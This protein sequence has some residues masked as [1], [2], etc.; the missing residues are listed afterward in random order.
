[1]SASYF[2]LVDEA[3]VKVGGET[4]MSI[5]EAARR[6][7]VSHVTL[8]LAVKRGELKTYGHAGRST[9]ISLKEAREWKKRYYNADQANRV[10]KRWNKLVSVSEAARRLGISV[11]PLFRAIQRG[12]LKVYGTNKTALLIS[13]KEAREWKKH[14]YHPEFAARVRVRWERER[15][16]KVEKMRMLKRT[17]RRHPLGGTGVFST[18]KTVRDRG[19]D[20]NERSPMRHPQSPQRRR[21]EPP[22]EAL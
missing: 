4:L 9:L 8:F 11:T 21:H 16:K 20:H 3:M 12:E 18:P 13:F 17:M 5:R 15:L 1:M 2:C 19:S 10:R 6:L 14:N 7:G 22:K